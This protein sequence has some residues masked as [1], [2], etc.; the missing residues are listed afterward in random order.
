MNI[1]D[2]KKISI[3]GPSG[4]GK[5]T[6][7]I[8]LGEILSLPVHHIDCYFWKEGWVEEDKEVLRKKIEE[9]TNEEKWVIDGT[10]RVTLENRFEKSDLIIYLN[11]PIDFCIES[12]RKRQKAG[13]SDRV[14]LPMYLEETE[15]GMDVLA[16]WIEG[17]A[18]KTVE[19][20]INPLIAKYPDKVVELKN[21]KEVEKFLKMC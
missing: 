15:H 1:R 5:S 14:G 18:K 16:A 11:F 3:I 12:I 9:I 8:K 13:K 2:I 10:Y 17:Y 20:H 6:L 4:T 21:R 19:P 7:A